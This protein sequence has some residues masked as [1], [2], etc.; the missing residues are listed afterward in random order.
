VDLD[1]LVRDVVAEYKGGGGPLR[2]VPVTKRAKS[3]ERGTDEDGEVRMNFAGNSIPTHPMYRDHEVPSKAEVRR[4]AH[5]KMTPPSRVFS[6]GCG[7]GS[8]ISVMVGIIRAI[9]H[10]ETGCI[11]VDDLPA[12]LST[13]PNV[14]MLP[15]TEWYHPTKV[16]TE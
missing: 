13:I 8:S 10:P 3:T 11:V 7:V 2:A 5:R 4:L 14:P 15:T 16:V 1:R 9:A 6:K 12:H